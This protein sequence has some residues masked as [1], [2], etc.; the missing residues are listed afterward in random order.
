MLPYTLAGFDL[1]TRGYLETISLDHPTAQGPELVFI[2][3]Y[4]TIRYQNFVRFDK[5]GG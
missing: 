1:T 4:F 3:G 5:F 2:F